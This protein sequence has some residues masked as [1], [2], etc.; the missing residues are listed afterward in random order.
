MQRGSWSREQA[1]ALCKVQIFWY[2]ADCYFFFFLSSWHRNPF[3]QQ[4]CGGCL[5]CARHCSRYWEYVNKREYADNRQK[6][7]LLCSADKSAQQWLSARGGTWRA[8]SNPGCCRPRPASLNSHPQSQQSPPSLG[9]V[10]A[11]FIKSFWFYN[12]TLQMRKACLGE[13]I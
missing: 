2:K 11:L 4:T 3:I 1:C 9:T 13:V 7:S 5:R 8:S 12:I 6:K 10:R